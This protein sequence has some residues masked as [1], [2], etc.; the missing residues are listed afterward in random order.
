MAE[1]KE[2]LIKDIEKDE[3]NKN[4]NYSKKENKKTEYTKEGTGQSQKDGF[5]DNPSFWNNKQSGTKQDTIDCFA[6]AKAFAKY[7]KAEDED[8]ELQNKCPKDDTKTTFSDSQVVV[9][10]D[11]GNCCE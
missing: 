10:E 8:E 5:T 11:N 1:A 3:N 7:D 9:D 6:E 4:S 2:N